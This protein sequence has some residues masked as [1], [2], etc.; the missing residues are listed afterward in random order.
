MNRERGL[1]IRKGYSLVRVLLNKAVVQKGTF[2]SSV[3]IHSLRSD[4]VRKRENTERWNG[5][6]LCKCD[7]QLLLQSPSV[8]I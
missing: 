2:F 8:M 6:S 4:F 5:I 1:L 3:Y 7:T